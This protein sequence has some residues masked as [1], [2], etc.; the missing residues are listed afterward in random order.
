MSPQNEE[1]SR[2]LLLAKQDQS[3]CSPGCRRCADRPR[4]FHAQ[5]AVEKTLKAAM[6]LRG[7]EFQRT[8]DL[9]ELAG[10]LADRDH[11]APV[12]SEDLMRLTP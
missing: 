12:S 9:E 10:Q 6:Y 11:C 2:L 1:A 4:V 7:L 3:A 5:Q 8:H